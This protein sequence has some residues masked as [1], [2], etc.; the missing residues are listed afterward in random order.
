MVGF[1]WLSTP[2]PFHYCRVKCAAES[3]VSET[4][5]RKITRLKTIIEGYIKL[6]VQS[7]SL[8]GCRWTNAVK[9]KCVGDKVCAAE[10]RRA[11]G[12]WHR[13]ARRYDPLVGLGGTSLGTETRSD[14]QSVYALSE[15]RRRST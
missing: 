14:Y 4:V 10:F 5:T 13:P 1:G 2:L 12:A 7:P 11:T 6:Q 15:L 9:T 8:T 3:A